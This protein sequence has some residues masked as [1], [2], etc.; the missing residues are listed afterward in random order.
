LRNLTAF[1]LARSRYGQNFA[2]SLIRLGSKKLADR[3]AYTTCL[4]EAG[5]PI[6]YCYFPNTA[7]ASILNVMDDGKSVEVGLA[8]WEASV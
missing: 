4:Q 7:M 5:N 3:C 6:Q 1:T 8:G 2:Y